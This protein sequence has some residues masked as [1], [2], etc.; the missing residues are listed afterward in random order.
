MTTPAQSVAP[1][2]VIRA[3]NLWKSYDQGAIH[4]LNGVHLEAI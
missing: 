1:A 4:V 3:A 2:L